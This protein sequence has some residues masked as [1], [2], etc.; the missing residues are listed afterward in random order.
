MFMTAI[1][2][3]SYDQTIPKCANKL[4][5]YAFLLANTV[6]GVSLELLGTGKII[7]QDFET[8]DDGNLEIDFSQLPEGLLESNNAIEL[9]V[10]RL[11]YCDEIMVIDDIGYNSIT[12]NI[13]DCDN[14][15]TV[16]IPCQ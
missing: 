8:D 16:Y 13:T 3:T 11:Y 7:Q 15:S 5:I 4:S 2:T 9:T 1:C 10:A 6:Y 14:T 12:L